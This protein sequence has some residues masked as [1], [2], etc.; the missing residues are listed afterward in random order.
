[1]ITGSYGFDLAALLPRIALEGKAEDRG[2]ERRKDQKDPFDHLQK[3]PA[4]DKKDIITALNLD[5]GRYGV[6]GRAVGFDG[7]N[8][9][10][11]IGRAVVVSPRL[12][13]L[14]G[15]AVPLLVESVVQEAGGSGTSFCMA[16]ESAP[17]LRPTI[18]LFAIISTRADRLLA[19]PQHAA[20]CCI[21]G[22]ESNTYC[23]AD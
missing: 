14:L 5:L 10:F 22:A 2:K 9:G 8:H 16:M 7:M 20:N 12:E 13:L 18:T 19:P 15:D 23:W 11:H 3:Q 6:M 1:M 4:N 21:S 17:A